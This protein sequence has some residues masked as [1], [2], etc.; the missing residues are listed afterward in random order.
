MAAQILMLPSSSFNLRKSFP[1]YKSVRTEMNWT[2]TQRGINTPITLLATRKS[3][4]ARIQH[5][6]PLRTGASRNKFVAQSVRGEAQAQGNLE[7][8]VPVLIERGRT[9]RVH[10]DQQWGLPATV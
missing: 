6:H 9:T 4:A 7:T 8:V 10:S 2:L 5:D 3:F 1:G